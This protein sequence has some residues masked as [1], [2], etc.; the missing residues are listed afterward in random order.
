MDFSEEILGFVSGKIG[1]VCVI[2]AGSGNIEY[3]D[4]FF[5]KKYGQCMVDQ[6]ADESFLWLEDC[7]E[8]SEDS[9]A[10]WE[11]IDTDTRKYY[12]ILSGCF[13]KENKKYNI[14]SFT[15]ITE[16]MALN[17]DV[18]K[19]M[20]FFKKLSKFQNAV[21]ERLSDSYF[22]LLPMITDYFKTNKSYLFLQRNNHLHIISFNSLG[23]VFCND[24]LNYTD[25]TKRIF[26]IDINDNLLNECL[27][28]EIKQA[29]IANGANMENS[30]RMLTSGEV[31]DQKFAIYINVWPNMDEQSAN[32][33]TLRNV[34]RLYV[35]N[36]LMRE[37]LLYDSE[38]DMLTGLY[39]KAKYLKMMDEV[40]SKLD[41]IGIFN[42]DLN[43]LKQMNDNYGHE[44]GDA[45]LKKAADSIR[46]VTNNKIYGYRV[47]GDEFMLIAENI[48][49]DE[50]D[51]LKERWEKSL[52][53]LNEA[54]DGVNCVIAIGV[55][56]GEGEYDLPAL[57][58]QADELMYEDKKAK[59]KPGEEIR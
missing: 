9:V 8:L 32:E 37:K 14:H 49:K 26:E 55:V 4:D 24:R 35:E 59:K 5:T 7:P 40:Y 39:N 19:Y 48:K 53:H 6:D 47:G 42:M 41:S 29:F 15:D 31:Y 56:H 21:L 3:A 34:I 52:A 22:E 30:I 36:G 43:Y 10:E 1:G 46:K 50:L 27:P 44:A 58:K 38:H 17:R 33:P 11:Y 2:A 20:A 57:L 13:T 51:K 25:D 18:T 45:L 12:R 54:D 23:D 16:Y 28:E